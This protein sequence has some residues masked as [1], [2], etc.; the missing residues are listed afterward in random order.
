MICIKVS[1]RARGSN[2]SMKTSDPYSRSATGLQPSTSR[3]R[4]L[5]ISASAA[6]AIA[7]IRPGMLR[8]AAANGRIT[9]GVVGLGGRGG[10]IAEHVSKHPRFHVTAVA[11]YFPEVAKSVGE[12]LKVPRERCF[13]GLH[14]YR[15]VIE[16]KVEA[17]FLETPPYFFPEHAQAAVAAGCHV[18]MAK[19]V[20]VDVPGS[21]AILEAG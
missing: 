20:A 6:A 3:R 18:Y 17:I 9:A 4:F 16:S 10:W 7:L 13:S 11:D 8:G 1:P 21:L 12:K 15:R 5:G 14:A 19:P 2:W